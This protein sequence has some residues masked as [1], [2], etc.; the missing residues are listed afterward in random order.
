MKKFLVVLIA[1]SLVLAFSA[2]AFAADTEI[3]DFSDI[4]DQSQAAQVSIMKLA[5]LGVLTGDNGLGGAYRPADTLTRAEFTKIAVYLAGK[6]GSVSAL[7]S[8]ASIFKDVAKGAWYTGY[9]NVAQQNGMIKGYADGTFKPESTITYAEA[10]TILLRSVGY[11]DNLSGSW[12]SNYLSKG[13]EIGLFD[14]VAQVNDAAVTRADMAIMSSNALG[15][16][17]VKYVENEIAQGIGQTL[18]GSIDADGYTEIYYYTNEDEDERANVTL[19]Y[20]SFDAYETTDNVFD[21]APSY[22]EVEEGDDIEA[23]LEEA[24][25]WDYSDYDEGQLEFQFNAYDSIDEEYYEADDLE[26]ADSYYIYGGG[27]GNLSGQVANFIV[28]DDDEVVFAEITSTTKPISEFEAGDDATDAITADDST[29]KFTSDTELKEI[30]ADDLSP[31]AA[32]TIDG[33][34]GKVYLDANGRWYAIRDYAD[35]EGFAYGY[36]DEVDDEYITFNSDNSDIADICIDEDLNDYNDYLLYNDGAFIAASDLKAGDVV[37]YANEMDCGVDL[38]VVKSAQSASLTNSN[39]TDGYKIDGSYYDVTANSS[40]SEDGGSSF[41]TLSYNEIAKE[42]FGTVTYVP[43][44][45]FNTLAYVS[46]EYTDTTV[47]GVITGL[48]ASTIYDEVDDEY[49]TE[50]SAVTIFN[51]DGEKVTYDFED[52]FSDDYN[53]AE[54][55]I[56]HTYRKGDMVELTVNDDGDV[57]DVDVAVAFN[58]V[59]NDGNS[60]NVTADEDTDR[61][62]WTDGTKQAFYLDEDTEIFLVSSDEGA[63]DDVEIQSVSSALADDFNCSEIYVYDNAGNTA[64][65]IYIL[66]SDE[67]S[68]EITPCSF[69]T[70]YDMDADGYYFTTIDDEKIYVEDGADYGTVTL[71]AFYTYET[72]GGEIVLATMDM[73]AS[74]AGIG[75]L[76][77]AEA[78]ALV[79]DIIEDGT[80]VVAT[81]SCTA[82]GSGTI[83]IGGTVYNVDDNTFMY[84]YENQLASGTN[85]AGEVA[86]VANFE[87]ATQVVIIYDSYANDALYIFAY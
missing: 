33:T 20:R 43:A 61:L 4:A 29:I 73:V 67:A 49:D 37:Y 74:T 21:F 48:T 76:T 26:V 17:V 28:N 70:D 23:D 14:D 60:Y 55:A 24:Y 53:D 59:L 87:G 35:Y 18:W 64:N 12:P 40:Y 38:Y 81:G 50:I 52:D 8:S 2:T 45:A 7:A 31:E 5:A 30:I 22:V 68:S 13:Q 42:A 84:A 11:D 80:A 72:S 69:F 27:L 85:D 51:A 36:V 25:G 79:A 83:T 58:T 46:A 62:I 1:I 3:A 66:D 16:N 63:Y 56:Y 19:L 77:T 78:T 34:Y 86:R 39:S 47:Y 75:A 6:E 65:T 9:V 54:N 41:V 10:S 32:N 71:D 57:T 15:L 82:A 44:Y